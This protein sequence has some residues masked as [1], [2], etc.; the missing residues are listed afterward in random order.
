MFNILF[1]KLYEFMFYYINII[2]NKMQFIRLYRFLQR[3]KIYFVNKSVFVILLMTCLLWY[4][5]IN[6]PN[7]CSLLNC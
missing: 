6:F 3:S 4:Y 1:F 7:N 2:I 5:F